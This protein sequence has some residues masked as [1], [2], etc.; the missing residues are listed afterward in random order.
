MKFFEKFA[1][2]VFLFLM[3]GLVAF[4]T[5]VPMPLSSEKVIL[6]IIGGLMTEAAKGV[7]KLVGGEDNE[8]I[9]Q[10]S[11]IGRL[12]N[13][14]A[15]LRAQYEQLHQMHMHLTDTLL[16]HHVIQDQEKDQKRG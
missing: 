5:Y 3:L 7:G 13:E 12:E 2:L 1:A 10:R 4:L 16:Q 6:I 11:R 14:L 8:K 9:E 15:Q